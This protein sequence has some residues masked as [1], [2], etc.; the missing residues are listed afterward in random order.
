MSYAAQTNEIPAVAWVLYLAVVLWALVY[1][2]MYA[3]VDKEDDLKIGIK[4]TAILFGDYDR[5]IMAV[6]Q[7]IILGLL[8]YVGIMQQLSWIYYAALGF[9]SLFFIYQQKLIFNRNR[10]DCFK[11]FLNSNWFGLTVFIGLVLEY[12]LA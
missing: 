7:L 2:T 9:G 4:S 3:M 10:A 12:A 11:A 5:E 6:L 8:A 1:D